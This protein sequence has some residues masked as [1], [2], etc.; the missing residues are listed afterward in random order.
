MIIII[1]FIFV[2]LND[3]MPSR[4]HSFMFDK[5]NTDTVTLAVVHFMVI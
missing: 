2:V 5:A 3:L 4:L 1:F